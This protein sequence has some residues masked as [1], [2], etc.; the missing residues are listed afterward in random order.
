MRAPLDP[1]W[2]VALVLVAESGPLAFWS[3]SSRASSAAVMADVYNSAMLPRR[4]ATIGSEDP[5]TCKRAS[6]VSSGVVS[7]GVG[8][9]EVGACGCWK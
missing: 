7:A 8:F 2:D 1:V 9:D 3:S 5:C 4:S 6:A